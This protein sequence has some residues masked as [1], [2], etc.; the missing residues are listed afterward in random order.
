LFCNEEI[1]W[2]A[3]CLLLVVTVCAVELLRTHRCRHIN[4]LY[5][6]SIFVKKYRRAYHEKK[7]HINLNKIIGN[8]FKINTT[9]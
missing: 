6:C 3:C 8:C 2:V 1:E 9:L 5:S 7:I 4:M